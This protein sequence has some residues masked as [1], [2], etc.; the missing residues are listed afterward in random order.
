[1]SG[2]AREEDPATNNPV[3]H[4]VSRNGLQWLEGPGLNDPGS[5]GVSVSPADQHLQAAGLIEFICVQNCS[6]K[7]GFLGISLS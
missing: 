5:S 3:W 6:N 7:G 2:S 4:R 1:M